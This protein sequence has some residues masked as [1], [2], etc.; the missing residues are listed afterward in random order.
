[1]AGLVRP[2]I[3]YSEPLDVEDH[4]KE[5]YDMG[6][7]VKLKGQGLV[8]YICKEYKVEP[9]LPRLKTSNSPSMTLN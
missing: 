4:M 7:E 5:T 9:V 3:P 8:D 2:Y 6:V 1:M